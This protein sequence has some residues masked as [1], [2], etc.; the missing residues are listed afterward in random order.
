[1]SAMELSASGAPN[2][3]GGGMIVS[4]VAEGTVRKAPNVRDVAAAYPHGQ[5]TVA[6]TIAKQGL[7]VLVAG[8]CVL[9]KMPLIAAQK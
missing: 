5:S 4:S 3:A 2:R 8:R 1:M 9:L 7:N 6:T